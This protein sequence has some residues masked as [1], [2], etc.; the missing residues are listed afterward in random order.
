MSTEERGAGRVQRFPSAHLCHHDGPI[1]DD[2]THCKKQKGSYEECQIGD[3]R[4]VLTTS[5]EMPD[6]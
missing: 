5:L 3:Q 1:V 2:L 4:I 6:A